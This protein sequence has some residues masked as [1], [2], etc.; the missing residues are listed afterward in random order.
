MIETWKDIPGYDGK[1]QA[2]KEWNIR[3]VFPSGKTRKMTPYHR[4][5]SGSQRLVVKLTKD[6]KS[7]EEIVVQLIA[8][9]FLGQ[10]PPG[11]VPYHV[12]GCQ[13][14]NYVNNIK[15]IS[16]RE[17]GKL[18]GA[19]S[20]RRPVAKM[21]REGDTVEVYPSART[22]AK[23]NFMSYQTVIDR[24]NGKCKSAFASD[25]MNYRGA[26]YNLRSVKKA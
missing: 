26:W 18:T 16:R 13:L 2:D 3:R 24:C 14:D 21:D 8:K 20:R 5:M 22:A 17:L 4:K 1:Y 11:H 25:G 23:K 6:G 10:P 7:K 9:T 15:Y 12:N 19:K